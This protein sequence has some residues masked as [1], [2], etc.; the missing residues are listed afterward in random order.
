MAQYKS[1]IV[2]LDFREGNSKL[3]QEAINVAKNLK[4]EVTLVHAV[5]YLP[6][7]P[8]FPYDEKKIEADLITELTGKLNEVGKFFTDAGVKVNDHII[9]KGKAYDIICGGAQD[10]DACAIVV[11]V[12]EHH[13]LENLIGS[14]ANKVINNAKRPVFLLNPASHMDGIKKI[15]CAYDFSDNAERAL[16]NAMN[17]AENHKAHLDIL[18]VVQEHFYFNPIAPVIDPNSA[19]YLDHK[20]EMKNAKNNVS[21]KLDEAIKKHH[22]EGVEYK[23]HIS[24]GDPV[25]E[26]FKQI[27]SLDSDLLV[28]GGSGHNALVRFVLGSTSE[29]IIRKA[30]CSIM[31]IKG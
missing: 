18:H 27:D 31:T 20:E 12:G 2:A 6:Y 26:I 16:I 4:A 30:P 1:L 9:R 14:T 29:K 28:L 13:L 25:R 21:S 3:C 8:Y 17:M 7:Y 10:I 11:G 15:I 19:L 23:I 5:E 24:Q 22:I